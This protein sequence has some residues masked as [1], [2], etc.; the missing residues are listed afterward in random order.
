MAAMETEVAT[1]REKRG[2]EQ[3]GGWDPQM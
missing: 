2:E 3:V 1:G